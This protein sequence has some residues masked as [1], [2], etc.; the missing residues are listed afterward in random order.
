M[1]HASRG[2]QAERK[3]GGGLKKPMLHSA[4]INFVEDFA[5]ARFCSMPDICLNH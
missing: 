5:D 3:D 1:C 2:R 4:W